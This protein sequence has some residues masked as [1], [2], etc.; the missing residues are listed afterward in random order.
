MNSSDEEKQEKSKSCKNI[1]PKKPKKQVCSKPVGAKKEPKKIKLK[2]FTDPILPSNVLNSKDNTEENKEKEENHIILKSF[3][4]P[5]LPFEIINQEIPVP[6][7][8]IPQT[9]IKV[10]AISPPGIAS[11]GEIPPEMNVSSSVSTSVSISLSSSRL[12]QPG[13]EQENTGNPEIPDNSKNHIQLVSYN[14][15][16]GKLGETHT[17]CDPFD[18]I[19][20]VRLNRILDKLQTFTNAHA[21]ICLQEIGQEWISDFYMFFDNRNYCFVITQYGDK[22]NDFMGVGIA[23]PNSRFYMLNFEIFKVGQSLSQYD[24]SLTTSQKVVKSMCSFF[25]LIT[26]R[27]K[28][29]NVFNIARYKP[30]NLLCVLL[31]D[32]ITNNKFV[33]STYHMPCEYKLPKVMN[34]HCALSIQCLQEWVRIVSPD[35][36]VIFAGDFNILPFSSSYDLF[37]LGSI[38]QNHS[39]YPKHKFWKPKISHTFI[40]AYKYVLGTEPDF[41]NYGNH[42]NLEPFVGTLDYIFCHKINVI[43]VIRIPHISDI[44]KKCKRLPDEE[45]PSDHLLIGMLFEI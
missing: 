17:S 31:R 8:V 23:F 6:Q 19:P 39:E 37:R 33:V 20:S 22:S 2:S 34:I 9:N 36:P 18:I 7:P 16:C 32:K 1:K 4:D 5:I 21:I 14:I 11:A 12:S 45:N 38:S 15:L 28:Y 40:S 3:T 25:H 10:P 26:L 41:T 30:N 24:E 44:G 43:D 27:K 13:V 29:V 35:S 42:G